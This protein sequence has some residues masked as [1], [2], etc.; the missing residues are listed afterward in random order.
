ME[1]PEFMFKNHLVVLKDSDLELLESALAD[2]E[3]EE[4]K[5]AALASQ[6][7]SNSGLGDAAAGAKK[8]G[9]PDPKAKDAKGGAKGKAA[10]AEAE[11]N[12]PK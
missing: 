4:Q 12:A 8:G 11:K 10:N 3:A 9:K 5:R 6:E 1:R 2:Q 7:G